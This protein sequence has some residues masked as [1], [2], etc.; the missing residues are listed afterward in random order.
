MRDTDECLLLFYT[1]KFGG[2][3][4]VILN[5]SRRVREREKGEEGQGKKY[6]YFIKIKF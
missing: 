6:I 2:G 1:T 5:W 3:V 4:A